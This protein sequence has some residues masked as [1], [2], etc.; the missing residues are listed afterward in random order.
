MSI[1]QFRPYVIAFL[2]YICLCAVAVGGFLYSVKLVAN[3]VISSCPQG[4]MYCAGQVFAGFQEG[5]LDGQDEARQNQG[6]IGK[7][8]KGN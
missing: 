7:H 1:F 5:F 8:T 3:H 6:K 2:L 4:V